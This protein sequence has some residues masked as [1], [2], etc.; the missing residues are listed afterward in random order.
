[1]RRDPTASM[2]EQILTIFETSARRTQP[3]AE[4]VL[5][6]VNSDLSEAFGCRFAV[7]LRP[8]I[9]RASSSPF[10]GRAID[11]GFKAADG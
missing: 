8:R 10:A 6:I 11:F 4:R 7:L 3:S 1:M 2:P 5:Q 9:S